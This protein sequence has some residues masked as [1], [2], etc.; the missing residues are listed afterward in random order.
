MLGFLLLGHNLVRSIKPK[1]WEQVTKL[2]FDLYNAVLLSAIDLPRGL[3]V[4]SRLDTSSSSELP[5]ALEA[6]LEY[7]PV[8]SAPKMHPKLS[9]IHI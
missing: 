8:F 2:A 7:W 9:L 1:L 5:T 4:I 6:G 3:V